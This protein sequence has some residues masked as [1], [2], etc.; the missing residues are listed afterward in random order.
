M[1]YY[2]VGLLKSKTNS[3]DGYVLL[4]SANNDRIS[5]VSK[6][7]LIANMQS[8][9][10][11]IVN[12]KITGRGITG[13]SY[14]L[15]SLSS[16][17]VTGKKRKIV[18]NGVLAVYPVDLASCPSGIGYKCFRLRLDP[19][20]S[21][22]GVAAKESLMNPG[23]Q[24]INKINGRIYTGIDPNIDYRTGKMK[25]SSV[26]QGV[27]GVEKKVSD[28]SQDTVS[29]GESNDNKLK[30]MLEKLKTGLVGYNDNKEY[31]AEELIIALNNKMLNPDVDVTYDE[32]R[33]YMIVKGWKYK[34]KFT[35]ADKT[36]GIS[37]FDID[38]NCTVLHLPRETSRFS[39]VVDGKESSPINRKFDLLY[40][41]N[42]NIASVEYPKG[43][44]AMQSSSLEIGILSFGGHRLNYNRIGTYNQDSFSYFG[45]LNIGK[46]LIPSI[47][48]LKHIGGLGTI[49]EVDLHNVE[50]F[51]QCF[52][53]T[54]FTKIPVL[55]SNVKS[56]SASFIQSNILENQD[57]RNLTSIEEIYNSFNNLDRH[58]GEVCLNSSEL[59]S[60]QSSFRSIGALN[61]VDL[62]GC[63]YL[64]SINNSFNGCSIS[65]IEFQNTNEDAIE[66]N[67]S[68][69]I[70]IDDS[71]KNILCTHIKLPRTL[72]RVANCF[73]ETNQDIDIEIFPNIK[74]YDLDRS[75]FA[76]N[77]GVN[78]LVGFRP[79]LK[80]TIE[81]LEVENS[82]FPVSKNGLSYIS[83]SDQDKDKVSRLNA[84]DILPKNAQ[85]DTNSLCGARIG[86]FDTADF[87]RLKKITSNL[88]GMKD[89]YG[90]SR[91]YIDTII[92]N[93]NIKKIE[94]EGLAGITGVRNLYISPEIKDIDTKAFANNGVT[95]ICN[96]YTSSE[97]PVVKMLKNKKG[98]NLILIDDFDEAVS[99]LKES[100]NSETSIPAKFNMILRNN[101]TYSNLLQSKYADNIKQA[102]EYLRRLENGPS[103]QILNSLPSLDTSNWSTDNNIT[104]IN[105]SELL[106][107]IINGQ[108]G[109]TGNTDDS[110]EAEQIF[111]GL[112]NMLTRVMGKSDDAL[113][114][115]ETLQNISR[116]YAT[117]IRRSIHGSCGVNPSEWSAFIKESEDLGVKLTS[118]RYKYSRGNI[119]FSELDTLRKEY[120]SKYIKAPYSL[121]TMTSLVQDID[122][123][124]EPMDRRWSIEYNSKLS[125][126]IQLGLRFLYC[127]NNKS[128]IFTLKLDCS[129]LDLDSLGIRVPSESFNVLYIVH[130]GRVVWARPL[131]TSSAYNLRFDFNYNNINRYNHV[132]TI[133]L[134][135]GDM[136]V[137]SDKNIIGGIE[138]GNDVIAPV[139][140]KAG[141]T[142][143]K[144]LV[145]SL[146]KMPTY[147]DDNTYE[148]S[149][150]PLMVR[151][152]GSIFPIA[153]KSKSGKF[154]TQLVYDVFTQRFYEIEACNATGTGSSSDLGKHITANYFVSIRI[155]KIWNI[156]EI[157]SIPS[158]YFDIL[159]LSQEK[160]NTD[161]SD[162]A[163]SGRAYDR[164]VFNTG[165]LN[166]ADKLSNKELYK[167][168][169]TQQKVLLDI[170]DRLVSTLEKATPTTKVFSLL[171]KAGLFTSFKTKPSTFSSKT[172]YNVLSNIP[173]SSSLSLRELKMRDMYC[174]GNTPESLIDTGNL[175]LSS[176]KMLIDG[177]KDDV[178]FANYVYYHDEP[179]RFGDKLRTFY[180][181]VQSLG[182]VIKLLKLIGASR[183]DGVK[184][185]GGL[186]NDL[187]KSVVT[188]NQIVPFYCAKGMKFK[189]NMVTKKI[190]SSNR[191]SEY[192]SE[193]SEDWIEYKI[194]I[195]VDL[196]NGDIYS[197][198]VYGNCV[199]V[200]FR[201]DDMKSA[202]LFQALT[203]HDP[204]WVGLAYGITHG[205]D[206]KAC[207]ELYALRDIIINGYN[208]EIPFIA[209]ALR[210][211]TT[212]SDGTLRCLERDFGSRFANLL[213][214]QM[215]Q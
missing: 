45:T 213:T 188:M 90:D 1:G 101:P 112:N 76:A 60:I 93:K 210:E 170:A 59:R 129:A 63:N 85:F 16:I 97:S 32:F 44:G 84:G 146:S 114:K 116:F 201:H 12:A 89:K 30:Q 42:D 23:V 183:A 47:T 91:C 50:K 121:D 186:S 195:G 102:Y 69:N 39:L 65:T 207:G 166:L 137:H 95:S 143:S 14:P 41:N 66:S 197:V 157:D 202:A 52:Q 109:L 154:Y 179:G 108:I 78:Y 94:I 120:I 168:D 46:L 96:V 162:S 132:C 150:H 191:T 193:T 128:A 87:P 161:F 214:K 164:F 190:I 169:T 21:D 177:T 57:L 144:G 122:I 19:T 13:D 74:D 67:G 200:L 124:Y 33:C 71:F 208:S 163:S 26:I 53:N 198:A 3:V 111:N 34:A 135:E 55:G 80:F 58:C 99:E 107:V 176:T 49:G 155:L 203:L 15:S 172:S 181:S 182:N 4:D 205:L 196:G 145:E 147:S 171:E 117:R 37:I 174:T 115:Q 133:G 8:N 180:T 6:S 212:A 54:Y 126:I 70:T 88:F 75:T 178:L 79:N 82:Y 209:E 38:Q 156:D 62:S 125:R 131:F 149:E 83:H 56:I 140:L 51:E 72:R 160:L 127:D 18:D 31:T 28:N 77:V 158:E 165:N 48:E 20:K 81:N 173:V 11:L 199:I 110:P 206:A 185:L 27:A 22:I 35:N 136:I 29:A 64:K 73:S 118:A 5:F 215:K 36:S 10:A 104:P 167:H 113:T 40:I 68:K 134:K 192:E 204:R 148:R 194:G 17:V 130:K 142:L 7:N 138:L 98:F 189:L 184:P 92:L 151:F 103:E 139:I 86:I 2:I 141:S 61:K 175:K 105:V 187:D 25:K 100:F 123:G 211:L 24:L 106:S 159:R 43:S 152:K 153:G 119:E 9:P